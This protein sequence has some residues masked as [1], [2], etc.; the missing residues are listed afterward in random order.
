MKVKLI[1]IFWLFLKTGSMIFGGGVVIIPLLEAEAVKKKSWVTSE[2]LIEYYAIS[3][4][5][6][7][8]N[9][10]DVSMFIGYKLRGKSGA[11][12]A[13]LGI[14]TVP[15]ILV[16]IFSAFISMISNFSFVK[17]AIWGVSIGTIVILVSAVK[18]IWK[19]SIPNPFTFLLFIAI[20]I[21]TAFTNISPVW[22]VFVA[23]ALGI[24]K[25]YISKEGEDK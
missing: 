19:N 23:L 17:T 13:G 12:A 8:L 4:L 15:F 14:I 2:E 11:V 21:L 20:F 7:G 18:T 10:P 24:I 9:I 5:I 22:F 6:P 3:Q 25:G 1:D 16:L